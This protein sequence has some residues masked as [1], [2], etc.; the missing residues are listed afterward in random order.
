VN[1]STYP[2]KLKS[3]ISNNIDLLNDNLIEKSVINYEINVKFDEQNIE[4]KVNILS[5]QDLDLALKNKQ[6]IVPVHEVNYLNQKRNDIR[7]SIEM[8][9]VKHLNEDIAK[10]FSDISFQTNVLSD[11]SSLNDPNYS[12]FEKFSDFYFKRITSKKIQISPLYDIYQIFDNILTEMLSEFISSRVKFS[13]NVYVIES[14]VL[15]RH[16]YY[17]KFTDSHIVMTGD[18]SVPSQ[19]NSKKSKQYLDA[20]K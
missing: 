4:N 18:M 12:I 3:L 10:L 17:Y 16:K 11:F 14:H 13:N 15:E 9:N 7:F 19:Y 20:R 8:S 5:Y 6:S 1:E 2:F